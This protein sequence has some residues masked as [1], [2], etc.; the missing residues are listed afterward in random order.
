MART[1]AKCMQNAK[2]RNVTAD[3]ANIYY[4]AVKA[5]YI[6]NNLFKS[7]DYLSYS[8]QAKIWSKILEMNSFGNPW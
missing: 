8:K 7:Q 6:I 4:R 1:N 2:Y 5:W 3:E